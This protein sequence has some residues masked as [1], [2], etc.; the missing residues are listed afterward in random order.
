MLVFMC[1]SLRSNCGC[2]AQASRRAREEANEQD[3]NAALHN[4]NLRT[5]AALAVAQ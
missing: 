3:T 1:R 2:V 4:N 5:L